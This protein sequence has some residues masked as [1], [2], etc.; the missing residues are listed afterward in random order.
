MRMT[1]APMPASMQRVGADHVVVLPVHPALAG[2]GRRGEHVQQRLVAALGRLQAGEIELRHVVEVRRAGRRTV[3]DRRF[4]DQRRFGN[5]GD[6]LAVILDAQQAVVGDA[7][8][9][10]RRGDPT[11]R[12]SRST[13]SSRPRFD[14]EQ[15]ALLRLGEHDLV[16]RHAGLALR[17]VRDVDLDAGAAAAR[18]L[19][20]SS[21][22]GR[23]RPC[24]GCRRARRSAISSRQASSSSFS[25]NGSPTCTAGR[26]SAERSSNSADA[27][28]APWMP[29]RP[30]L[31][32]T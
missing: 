15:H 12:R 27:I 20:R 9:C 2:D 16:G 11:C 22:S 1:P 7:R 4:V 25:M 21:R 18:H 29:S 10:A 5:L 23:P 31:A 8:R 19:A 30:V 3:V 28:V 32:P 24:P 26:F 14:H 6:D 13:S 17:H